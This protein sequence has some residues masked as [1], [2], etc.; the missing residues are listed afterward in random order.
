MWRR[1][2]TPSRRTHS[3][4]CRSPWRDAD[5]NQ[6]EGAHMTK[7]FSKRTLLRVTAFSALPAALAACSTGGAS[8]DQASPGAVPTLRRSVTL[9]WMHSADTPA[10]GEAR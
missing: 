4:C 1:G 6:E 10:H 7:H 2:A 5:L 9:Q 3:P 8:S